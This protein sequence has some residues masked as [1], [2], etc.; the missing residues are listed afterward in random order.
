[1]NLKILW[2]FW[3]VPIFVEKVFVK[4]FLRKMDFLDFED[5]LEVLREQEEAE[6]Q[7]ENGK[8]F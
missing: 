5:D 3:K 7:K 6:E 1:M 8:N 4:I 2:S